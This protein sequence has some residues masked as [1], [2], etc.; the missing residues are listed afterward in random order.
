MKILVTGASGLIGKVLVKK[1]EERGHI[2]HTLSR[3]K[4]EKTNEFQWDPEKNF[5]EDDAF[6][7]IE[8]VIHLAGATIAKRWTDFYKKELYSS[9]INAAKLIKSYCEKYNIKLNCFIS[10]SGINY[11]CTF[12]TN[13]I[14]TEETPIKKLDFLAQLS[15]DW[16]NAAYEFSDIAKRV[17]CIRTAMVLAKN[18]G[19]FVPLKKLTDFNLASPV[20]KANQWMNGIHIDDLVEMYVQS[21]ENESINGSYNAV[22]DETVSNKDFMKTLAEKSKKFFLPI[23]VPEFIMKLVL[24]EMSS[25]ILE[26]TRASNQKIKSTGFNFKFPNL[27]KA[28][29]DLL[30][31]P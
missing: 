31:K 7:G 17:V 21:I 1:L 16:E 18:G 2:I 28:L 13:E 30:K 19:S 27:E 20:G 10:A 8:A 11:Y 15:K 25:I 6:N 14:L 23:A 9:R 12:T 24:G 26:G 29:D 22:A 3:K 5:I 4:S